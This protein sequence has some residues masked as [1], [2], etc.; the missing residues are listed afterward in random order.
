M[1]LRT[2]LP[3]L[4]LPLFVA[5]ASPADERQSGST[6][7]LARPN[8]VLIVA[9]DLGWGDLGCYGQTRIDTPELDRLAAEG[10]RFTQFYAGATVCAP[11]RSALLTGQHTGRTRIRGNKR[12]DLLP[13]DVTVAEI[14]RD[15]GYRTACF[16]KWGVG[17]LG[18][19]G[20]PTR[21]GYERFFGYLDQRHA[22]NYYP[23]YLIDLEGPDDEDVRV[24]LPNVPETEDAIGAG[25]AKEKRVYSHDLITDEALAWLTA[26][27]ASDPFFLTL[28]WTIPH[29]NNEAGAAGMEVPELGRYADEDWPDP[30]KGFAAMVTRMDRDVGRVRAA[31]EEMGV[32]DDTLILFTSDNGP[33]S[34]GGHRAWFF[35]SS[36]PLQGK[37]RDLTEGGIR[38]PL[39]AWWPDAIEAGRESD[40]VA[41]FWDLLPTLAELAGAARAVPSGV[42]GLSFAPTLRGRTAGQ[43][44]HEDLYWAFYE[45]GAARALLHDGRWKAIQ[46]PLASPVRLYDL[47]N[48]L[49]EEVDLA[50]ERPELVQEL[51]RR[52]DA[53]DVPSAEWTLPEPGPITAGS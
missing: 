22:H 32:A 48:D 19:T 47:V 11:S 36:G 5:C 29:A 27:D 13:E 49:G 53:A 25:V 40:H 6:S 1:R 21:Q 4:G 50:A 51:V 14:L 8:V 24:E 3:L 41:A 26:R 15:A 43:P 9:D 42:D 10:L 46:Q 2:L 33:H 52:M 39:I 30:A 28:T 44:E 7:A 17:T 12:Q 35:G 18:G 45:R 16:G 34:E 31:L 37:K 23:T 20:I 38:V